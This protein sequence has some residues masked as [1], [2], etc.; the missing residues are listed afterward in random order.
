LRAALLEA[1]EIA[2]DVAIVSRQR[3]RLAELVPALGKLA[4]SSARFSLSAQFFGA[5]S[6]GRALDPA[7]LDAVAHK[8][9]VSPMAARRAQALLG[10]TPELDAI[11]RL[12]VGAVREWQGAF[13]VRA[14][15]PRGDGGW[16]TAIVL[17]E[18]RQ[19]VWLAGAAVD[20]ASHALLWRCLEALARH[21]GR[22][23]KST[24]F[25]EAWGEGEYHPL[26]HNNR[27]HTTI[28]KLRKFLEADPAN[29]KLLL[30]TEEGYAFSTDEP[31][32]YLGDRIEPPH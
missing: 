10:G 20:L 29:P 11:D 9:D 2:A 8:P 14:L 30:T 22:V 6:G 1:H 4:G 21:G 15:V 23:D 28:N 16:R 17:D 32:L 19:R 3:N 31:V 24:L 12:V 5:L 18:H 27:L 25:C 13:R 7:A 26:R